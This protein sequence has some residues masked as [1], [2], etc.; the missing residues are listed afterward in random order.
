MRGSAVGGG[1]ERVLHVIP[2]VHAH[3]LNGIPTDFVWNLYADQLVLFI[4]QVGAV[5]T[6]VSTT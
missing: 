5:G 3:L 6:V 2:Q 4:T 1:V